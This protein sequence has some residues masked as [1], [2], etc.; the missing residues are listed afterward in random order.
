MRT[1]LHRALEGELASLHPHERR[2]QHRRQMRMLHGPLSNLLL[3]LA[4]LEALRLGVHAYAD[5][6]QASSLVWQLGV[7]VAMLAVAISYRHL[8]ST[9]RRVLLGS[10][11]LG[12]LLISLA[13]LGSEWRQMPALS[14]GG[15]LLL[16]VAGLPV[17]VRPRVA[18]V[19]LAACSAAA[20]ALLFALEAVSTEER[21][22][23]GLFYAMSTVAGLTLRRAR[24]NLAIRL[25]QKVEILWQRAV[26]DPLTGLLNRQ[27]WMSL[28][29]T[30]MEEAI[31]AGHRP[32]L[33]FIDVDYFKRVNDAHGHLAGDEILRELG[34]LIAARVGPGELSARL[35]GEEFAC[36]L[37]DASEE[38]A[39]A[40]AMRVADD[41]RR[42]AARFGSTLSIGITSHRDG[43][44][45]ND[46]LARADAALYEAKRLGR[47]RIV[48][49]PED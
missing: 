43:D 6:L 10:V 21:Q 39:E 35:G 27:G 48:Y 15:F 1:S 17:L 23:F 16:P 25:D 37:P 33:L 20:G 34:H 5:W 13:G 30:A 42:S 32:V 24:A 3:A 45:L 8:A 12:M 46:M 36:L 7:T 49:A 4:L 31:A 47:D 22:L 28:A 38:K 26:S 40:F 18:L 11:F 9:R 2:E 41:Y 14:L 29:G 44:L 19:A